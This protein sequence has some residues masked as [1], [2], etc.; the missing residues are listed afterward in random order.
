MRQNIVAILAGVVIMIFLDFLLAKITPSLAVG[1][2]V[3]VFIGGGTAAFV[4]ERNGWLVGFSVGIVNVIIT[5][6]L[7]Y[8]IAPQVPLHESGYSMSDV[9]VRPIL[10]SIVYGIL[11]GAF[12]SRFKKWR[13]HRR[14]NIAV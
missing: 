11:G 2:S 14:R 7:F 6:T 12:G 8:W 9:V 10:L 4:V 3:S 5:L 1:I 13:I